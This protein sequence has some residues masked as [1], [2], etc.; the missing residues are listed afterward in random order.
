MLTAAALL[1]QTT[2]PE[3]V[4]NF[5]SPWPPQSNDDIHQQRP[6]IVRRLNADA[7]AVLGRS[8]GCQS[9][10]L[11]RDDSFITCINRILG[12]PI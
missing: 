11:E 6:V 3:Q 7:G 4:Q 5:V 2:I 9:C 12:H 1:L 8:T 10:S